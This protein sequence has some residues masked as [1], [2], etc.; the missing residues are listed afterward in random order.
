MSPEIQ[1]TYSKK[2]ILEV[3]SVMDEYFEY[4]LDQNIRDYHKG[5]RPSRY[6]TPL[7]LAL[8]QNSEDKVILDYAIKNNLIIVTCDRLFVIENLINFRNV[9]FQDEYNIRYYLKI[10]NSFVF[11]FISY[12]SIDLFPLKKK[13]TI[14]NKISRN[15]KSQKQQKLNYSYLVDFYIKHNGHTRSKNHFVYCNELFSQEV[16]EQ[17]HDEQLKY[18]L[19]YAIQNDLTII[20]KSKKLCIL[21]LINTKHCIFE[22]KYGTRHYITLDESFEF[23]RVNIVKKEIN[24]PSE[25]SI[26]KDHLEYNVSQIRQSLEY[27][28]RNLHFVETELIKRKE[29]EA[30]RELE[31][32][33]VPTYSSNKGDEYF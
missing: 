26:K 13:N 6:F 19:S 33:Q 22:D 21:S 11:D 12:D 1:I 18:V 32:L 23:E 2:N 5:T 20:T 4:L 16:L 25:I 28:N 7:H 30:L 17:K 8:P 24:L 10:K 15:I 29:L 31:S 3:K 9:I 27:A 14:F